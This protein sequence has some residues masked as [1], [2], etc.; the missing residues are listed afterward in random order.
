MMNGLYLFLLFLPTE[1]FVA[2]KIHRNTI[3]S[4]SLPCS[5]I[6]NV[7][8]SGDSSIQSCI[9][10]CVNEYNCQTGVYYDD[11]HVCTMYSELCDINHLQ[12]SGGVQAN[13]ICYRKNHSMLILLKLQQ[14]PFCFRS[15][16]YLSS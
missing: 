16:K 11:A 10:E 3:Y 12:P 4:S 1:A 13:V 14:K 15:D 2:V 7:S 9:W 8:L 5:F 6:R